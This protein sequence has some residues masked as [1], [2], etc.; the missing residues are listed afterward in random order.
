MTP[1]PSWKDAA[2]TVTTIDSVE[3]LKRRIKRSGN[4]YFMLRHGEAENN[5][6]D[7]LN[8][9]DVHLYGLTQRGQAQAQATGEQLKSAGIT[10]IYASPL[11]RTFETAQIAA[12]VIGIPEDAIIVDERL[13]EFNFGDWEGKN[14]HEF[15]A[16][17]ETHMSSCDD[18]IPGGESY[19]DARERF[20]D[21]I[22][23]LE[24]TRTNEVVLIVTH[25]IGFESL[26]TVAAGYDREK[27]WEVILATRTG[28][29]ET[30]ELPFVPLPHN[31]Y[32]ELDLHPSYLNQVQVLSE[33]GE[34]LTPMNDV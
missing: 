16:F 2:G 23:E 4:R 19:Q 26:E 31:R 20:G 8:G 10:T 13:R 24:R 11:R 15:L 22:Y 14:Y 6:K 34:P 9:R 32:Y 27:A 33:A 17:R 21:F 25:G 12:R 18:R 5:V 28:Y 7:V 1:L 3:E 29:G 30:R